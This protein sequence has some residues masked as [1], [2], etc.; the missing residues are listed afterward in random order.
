MFLHKTPSIVQW[1][2]PSLTW[3]VN[4]TQKVVY[5][6]FD[7]GPIPEVTPW[8]LRQLETFHAKATFFC[9]GENIVKYPDIFEQV[10]DA[11]HAVGNHTYNHLNGWKSSWKDYVANIHRASRVLQEDGKGQKLFRPPYGRITRKQLKALSGFKIIMWDVLSGDFS[12]KKNPEDCLKKTLV[13]TKPGAIVVFHDSL[14]SFQNLRLILP[15]YLETLSR[16]G[17][18]FDRL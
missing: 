5:L 16:E 14:K 3:R 7:D 13:H 12:R 10:T 4:T 1:V 6:T 9:V 18:K 17:Y 8:V 2:Y 11:G 15:R